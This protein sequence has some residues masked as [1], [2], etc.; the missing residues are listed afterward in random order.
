[1]VGRLFYDV[2]L[3]TILD[4]K[5]CHQAP[6]GM[7]RVLPPRSDLLGQGGTMGHATLMLTKKSN[8]AFFFVFQSLFIKII[9]GSWS[10]NSLKPLK[11]WPWY[12]TCS[13]RNFTY[14]R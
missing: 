2:C 8:E 11:I 5:I 3:F 13:N 9:L 4:L 12:T 10:L 1:M 14:N 7:F 6:L